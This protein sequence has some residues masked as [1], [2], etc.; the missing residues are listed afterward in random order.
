LFAPLA[1][2][3]LLLL[4]SPLLA[5]Y[6]GYRLAI[7]GKSR[8]GFAQRLGFAPRLETPPP[9]GRAW[10]HAVSAG[11]VV[12]AAAIARRLAEVS[13]ETEVVISTTTPAGQEQARR[14]LPDAA[15]HFYFPFDFLPCVALALTRVR[16]TAVAPVETEIWPNWLWL[17]RKLSIRTALL[18]GQFAD[19]G[20]RGARK[21][22]W[23]YRWALGNL[24]ALHLQTELSRER[25]LELGADAERLQVV[26]NVKFEQ[27]PPALK[28]E[29]EAVVRE[30]L[31]QSAVGSRQTADG[32]GQ[33][34]DGRAQTAGG[35]GQSAG[36]CRQGVAG[37]GNSWEEPSE[38]VRPL[39][40]TAAADCQLWIA[41]STHPG[42]EEQVLDAFAR[43]REALP[44]LKL[45]LAPR[46]VERAAE[47]RAV[48]EARGWSCARRS[49]A[50][51]G[52][53][54]VLVLDTMGELAGLYSL[55]DVV[56]VGGSLV[57]IGGHDILQPLFFGK[58][59]LFGPHMHN[60]RD[61]AALSL[62]AG[63]VRQVGDAEGLASAVV[64]LTSDGEARARIEGA[65]ERLLAEN[66]GAAL[67]CAQVLAKLA[68]GGR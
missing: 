64:E 45:L 17:A 57:P 62:G 68:R 50:P 22:K 43:A 18:N 56:F 39:L 6:L 66:T 25:A 47:V 23:L 28:P 12:A 11:E 33:E 58:P 24:E 1:Y 41:G 60:Q 2:N 35:R 4:G 63:A 67:E 7:K 36:G 30:A 55:A 38:P 13:P 9:G 49:A 52:P 5:L 3:G 59:T 61:L 51:A 54:D 65:A 19:R 14:L 15:A 26:G 10:L 48:V 34:V 53:V 21:A 16:P 20:Y 40:P 46:H 27:K 8:A 42:E 32:R 31:G 44:G 29:V 37:G